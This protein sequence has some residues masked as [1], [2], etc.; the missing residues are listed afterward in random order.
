MSWLETLVSRLDYQAITYG[1]HFRLIGDVL[2]CTGFLSYSGPFNQ[3]F[4]T[5]LQA[6]WQ[7]ELHTRRIPYSTNLNLTAMLVDNATVSKS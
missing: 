2:L 5:R 4:R 7:S 6:D 3:E 1:I